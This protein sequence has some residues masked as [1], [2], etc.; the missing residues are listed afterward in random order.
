M[1]D[2]ATELSDLNFPRQQARALEGY[3]PVEHSIRINDQFRICFRWVD[4]AK[5]VEITDY[6]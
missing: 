5:D 2:T 1:S 6:H 4:Q 3:V